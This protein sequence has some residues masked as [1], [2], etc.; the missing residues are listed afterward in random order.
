MDVPITTEK[1]QS[2]E[3]RLAL[4][5]VVKDISYIQRD[6]GDIKTIIKDQANIY[7]TKQE[8]NDNRILQDAR[9]IRLEKLNNMWKWL[10]PIIS[11]ILGAV[12]SAL[13]ISFIQHLK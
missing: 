13:V 6:M 7:V 4:N 10:S 5:G 11:V 8:Y 1:M 9:V 2:D 12:G 3:T